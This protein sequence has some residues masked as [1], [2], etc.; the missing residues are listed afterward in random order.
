MIPS[1]QRVKARIS[2]WKQ[3]PEAWACCKTSSQSKNS[4]SLVQGML[5]S[6]HWQHILYL[7]L[8]RIEVG[9]EGEKAG[10]RREKKSG[11]F[12][13]RLLYTEKIGGYCESLLSNA[14]VPG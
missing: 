11:A 3:S 12:V 9:N 8:R 7:V 13:F 6:L 1:R 14:V 10:G 5:M 4:G 2:A